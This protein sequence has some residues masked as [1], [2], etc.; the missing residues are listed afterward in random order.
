[1]QKLFEQI[2]KMMKQITDVLEDYGR[3]ISALENREDKPHGL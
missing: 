1:M 3:R 2:E